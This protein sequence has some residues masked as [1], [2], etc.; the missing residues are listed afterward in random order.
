MLGE[1]G[2]G[3]GVRQDGVRGEQREE[4]DEDDDEDEEEEVEAA[5][6]CRV[7]LH[8]LFLQS[9]TRRSVTLNKKSYCTR[10][11]IKAMQHP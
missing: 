9:R 8:R 1:D 4:E 7:S 2:H 3:R 6:S 5:L 11:F 10:T